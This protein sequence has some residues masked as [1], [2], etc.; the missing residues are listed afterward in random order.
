MYSGVPSAIP[1]SVTTPPPRPGAGARPRDPEVGEHGVA[2][3]KQDV[4]GL[5]VAV[6]E[7]LAVRVVERCPYVAGD[8]QRFVHRHAP[9]T[10]QPIAQRA[11][12]HVGSHVVQRAV[13]VAG[14]DEGQDVRMG[15]SCR[16]VDLA[17]E[18]L[19]AQRR[20]QLRRQHLQRHLAVVF[21]VRGEV[22]GGHAALSE[23][24]LDGVAARK[25]CGEL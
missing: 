17:Q 25:R 4:L 23:L 6:H 19:R 2:V 15:E 7:P 9:P 12:R 10:D 5:H 21:P 24:P 22:H 3:G 1:T 11:I 18:P 16:D 8:A 13:R 14:V 20:R